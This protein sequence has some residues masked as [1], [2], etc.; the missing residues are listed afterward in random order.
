MNE[1]I[2]IVLSGGGARGLAHAGV[3][4]ALREHGI[5]PNIVSGTSAGAL[6]GA[7]WAAGWEPSD[8]LRFFYTTSPFKLSKFTL[9][10]AG[11]LD[12]A[13]VIEDFREF[14]PDD[15]FEALERRLF[16]TATDLS[17]GRKVVFDS[18]PLIEPLLASC[19]F[20]MLFTPTMAHGRLCADG[21]ILDNFPVEQV[22]V[23]CR[24]VL[25]SYASPLQPAN[26][27]DFSSAMSVI[28]RSFDVGM[29]A[30]ARSKFNL[31][32]VLIAPKELRQFGLLDV[33]RLEEIYAIGYRATLDKM[34]QIERAISNG[35]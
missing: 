13:K 11:F 9:S 1:D 3:L 5:E 4:A 26:G 12:T 23:R 17:Q 25:G 16:V 22:S 15:A 2:G 28:Q 32:N 33:R 29:H 27:D 18:G 35:V 30:T 31:C 10:G 34:E 6:V 21:G 7:L 14:F 24:V 8:M 20:P 19:S